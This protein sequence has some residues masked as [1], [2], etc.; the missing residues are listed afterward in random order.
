MEVPQ[1]FLLLTLGLLGALPQGFA[2]LDLRQDRNFIGQHTFGEGGFL[3]GLTGGGAVEGPPGVLGGS[4]GTSGNLWTSGGVAGGGST[5]GGAG[6][7]TS[8]GVA[9]GGM[10]GGSTTLGG[11]GGMTGGQAGASILYPYGP[12]ERDQITP[13]VDDGFSAEVKLSVPFIFFNKK[14]YGVYV[15]NN[16]VVSFGAPCPQY[17]PDAFP[18]QGFVFVAPFWADVDVRNGGKV[19]YRE[20]TTPGLLQ[21][22]SNDINSYFPNINFQ[23][24]WTFIVTWDKVSYFGSAS[25]KKNTY[26]AVLASD[27]K[28]DFIILNYDTITWTTGS[29]SGGNR[30]TGLGG[31][32]AQAGFNAGDMEH[33]FNIPGSRTPDIVNIASTSNVRT[34]G[35]WVFRV[36]SFKVPGGCVAGVNFAKFGD[37]FWKDDSCEEKCICQPNGDSS[38]TKNECSISEVCKPSKWF[39]LCQAPDSCI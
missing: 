17:T 3:G 25:D 11:G 7:W 28:S 29:D 12:S 14:Y 8:G 19:Y 31:I 36:D 13:A 21:R 20:S 2:F 22:V 26:Q 1:A 4:W 15:N 5:G 23:A 9:G 6:G 30:W 32:P 24:T 39:F 18:I 37:I 33:Y 34:P 27:G 38:C 10:T 16:G 35:R